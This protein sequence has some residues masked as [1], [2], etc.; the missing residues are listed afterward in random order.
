[1]KKNKT[2]IYYFVLTDSYFLLFSQ[3]NLNVLIVLPDNFDGD[4]SLPHAIVTFKV[5]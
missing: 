1:M 2:D 4:S 3:I 5:F